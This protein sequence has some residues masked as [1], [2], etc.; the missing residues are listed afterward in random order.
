MATVSLDRAAAE[1]KRIE[2]EPPISAEQ[3]RA[4]QD[5]AKHG[6]KIEVARG[7]M[8]HGSERAIVEMLT[9]GGMSAERAKEISDVLLP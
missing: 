7:W 3:K 2:T 4:L 1:L 5:A 8:A 9:G 6:V